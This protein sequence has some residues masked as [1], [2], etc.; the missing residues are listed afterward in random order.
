MAGERQYPRMECRARAKTGVATGEV[1]SLSKSGLFLATE[2][3]LAPGAELELEF[4]LPD[5][6]LLTAV[7]EVKRVGTGPRPKEAGLG[8]RFLRINTEALAAIERLAAA[9]VSARV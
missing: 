2:A 1:R 7:G 4:Y 6:T 8:I 9:Q 3:T 5:G